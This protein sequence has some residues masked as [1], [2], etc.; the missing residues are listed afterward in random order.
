MRFQ[1][2]RKKICI[3]FNRKDRFEGRPLIKV[4]LEEFFRLHVSGASVFRT[5]A[6]F[7]SN[8]TLQSDFFGNP[9]KRNRGLLVQVIETEKKTYEILALCDRIIPNGIVTVEDVTLIRYSRTKVEEEDHKLAASYHSDKMS[10][11][12]T[13]LE[14]N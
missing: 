13:D 14:T 9:F 7:G 1:D 2:T 3:Y 4:M 5:R 8:Y 12:G 11:V 10:S 6:N